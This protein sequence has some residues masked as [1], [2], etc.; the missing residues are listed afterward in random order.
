MLG[1]AARQAD[2]VNVNFDLREGAVN[3][4]LVRWPRS[5]DR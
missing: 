4:N 1:L 3:R 2:I 5:G